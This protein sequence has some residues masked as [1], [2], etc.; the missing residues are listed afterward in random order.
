MGNKRS[1]RILMPTGS[2]S[3][4]MEQSRDAQDEAEAA[5]GRARAVW[6]T[7]ERRCHAVQWGMGQR[8]NSDN[9]K[10]TAIGRALGMENWLRITFALDPPRLKQGLERVTDM[11]M[12]VYLCP[13][14]ELGAK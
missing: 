14:N 7:G 1:F 2:D 13:W 10:R 11:P 4:P 6:R 3:V 8:E 9:R 5:H 12:L